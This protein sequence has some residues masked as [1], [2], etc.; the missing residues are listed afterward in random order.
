LQRE[1]GEGGAVAAFVDA[2]VVDEQSGGGVDGES[3]DEV[4]RGAGAGEV[5]AAAAAF[6]GVPE[7][8][9]F[10]EIALQG[11]VADAELPGEVGGG[12][13]AGGE[14]RGEV[15]EA[16]GLAGSAGG[17]GGVRVRGVGAPVPE[18][19]TGVPRVV[20]KTA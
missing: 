15:Q 10:L 12:A 18:P 2:G 17:H 5:V 6:D 20:V 16:G 1:L 11:A 3:L 4:E 14:V 9:E 19:P 13:G 7:F 8:G